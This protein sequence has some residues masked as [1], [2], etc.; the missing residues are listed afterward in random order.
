MQEK[1]LPI[2]EAVLDKESMEKE[3][4]IIKNVREWICRNGK[5]RKDRLRPIV[6]HDNLNKGSYYIG[7]NAAKR[8]KKLKNS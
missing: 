1:N 2:E 4:P 8:E 3:S 7:K 6:F 5:V